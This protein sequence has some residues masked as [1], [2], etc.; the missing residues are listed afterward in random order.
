MNEAPDLS[1]LVPAPP[2]YPPL[3]RFLFAA[4]GGSPKTP[5]L[6]AIVPE[7]VEDMMGTAFHTMRGVYSIVSLHRTLDKLIKEPTRIFPIGTRAE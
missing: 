5:E 4:G 1:M 6:P 7:E 3:P 2:P